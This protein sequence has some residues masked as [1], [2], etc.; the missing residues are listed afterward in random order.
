MQ[1]ICLM[2][3][4]GMLASR[5]MLGSIIPGAWA[6]RGVRMNSGGGEGEG[7]GDGADGEGCGEGRE[8]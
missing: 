7:E 1:T 5:R 4:C 8:E 3:C 6:G 2:M